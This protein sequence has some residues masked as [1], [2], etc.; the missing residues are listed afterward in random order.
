MAFSLGQSIIQGRTPASRVTALLPST[1]LVLP[2]ICR[3]PYLPALHDFTPRHRSATEG[4]SRRTS[5]TAYAMAA[6]AV[7]TM[8]TG[9]EGLAFIEDCIV[10]TIAD[11]VV[12]VYKICFAWGDVEFIQPI[13]HCNQHFVWFAQCCTHPYEM[14]FT[15]SIRDLQDISIR[16]VEFT[17]IPACQLQMYTLKVWTCEASPIWWFR[18]LAGPLSCA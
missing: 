4:I 17:E 2:S 3:R 10:P 5:G 13:D 12:V 6:G 15:G 11:S 9:E 8:P 1:P 7:F 16:L 18:C 14:N